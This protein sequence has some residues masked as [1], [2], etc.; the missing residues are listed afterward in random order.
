MA[1]S[2]V[3]M[4]Q[5]DASSAAG[6]QLSYFT[7]PSRIQNAPTLLRVAAQARYVDPGTGLG[8]YGRVPFAYAAGTGGSKSITDVGD[9]EIG[10][11]FSPR[12]TADGLGVILR[13]GITLPTGESKDSALVGTLANYLALPDLYNSLPQATTLK[14]GVSPVVR[15]GPVFARLDL[16]LD[17]NLDAKDTTI[18]KALHIN[19]GVGADVGPAAVMVESTNVTLFSDRPTANSESVNAFALSVRFDARPSSPYLALVLPV[20]DDL[21]EVVGFM[22]T[23]GIEFR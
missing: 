5:V 2:F 20:D 4:D 19:V 7:L 22:V 23:A 10:A 3:V 17:W 16:G 13:A 18:G 12:R 11:I 21:K 8:A 15:S 14:L 1:P 9:V 6:L